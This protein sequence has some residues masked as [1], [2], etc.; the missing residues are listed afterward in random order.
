MRDSR[1]NRLDMV[2]RAVGG[3][4][5]LAYAHAVERGADVDP[6]VAI[7]QGDQRLQNCGSPTANCCRRRPLPLR[8]ICVR[9]CATSVSLPA[10]RPS[11]YRTRH[12]R[13]TPSSS[14]VRESL[15]Y[16]TYFR[17]A[18]PLSFRGSCAHRSRCLFTTCWVMVEPPCSRPG[19]PKLPIKARMMPRSSMPWC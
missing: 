10:T 15:L 18:T 13:D 5:R 7:G 12:G 14:K 19:S 6:F 11:R 3:I 8:M 4:T 16:S 2:P 9:L 1:T 17:D